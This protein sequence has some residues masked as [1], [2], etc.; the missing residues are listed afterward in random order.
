[1]KDVQ[2][3]LTGMPSWF[4]GFLSALGAFL[5]PIALTL[6]WSEVTKPWIEKMK[7]QKKDKSN[8]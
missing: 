4:P 5:A 8:D 2:L 6:I 1:M 3:Q 7:K